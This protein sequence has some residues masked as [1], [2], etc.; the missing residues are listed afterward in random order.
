MNQRSQHTS[1]SSPALQRQVEGVVSAIKM[2]TKQQTPGEQELQLRTSGVSCIFKVANDRSPVPPGT[3]RLANNNARSYTGNQ[4]T[5]ITQNKPMLQWFNATLDSTRRA[6]RASVTNA[7][8]AHH[9]QSIIR[10]HVSIR[11]SPWTNG[12]TILCAQYWVS[13]LW[14]DVCTVDR[15]HD[16][17]SYDDRGCPLKVKHKVNMGSLEP[18][19]W[20]R[21]RSL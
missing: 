15:L 5:R 2:I 16:L 19:Q 10:I 20:K 13:R 1:T 6:K 21:P 12:P 7:C 14:E 18:D 9:A 8:K 4:P 3:A 17:S 11:N